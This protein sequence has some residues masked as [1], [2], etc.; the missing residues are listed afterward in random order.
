M[1]LYS[2]RQVE[3]C[4]TVIISTIIVVFFAIIFRV[5]R[6]T[7]QTQRTQLTAPTEQ[8][9]LIAPTEQTSDA[10]LLF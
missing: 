5:F 3:D 2:R 8:T 7:P 10:E 4:T 1:W 9:S 6:K